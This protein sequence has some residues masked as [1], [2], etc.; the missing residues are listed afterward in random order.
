MHGR[1]DGIAA[2]VF[3]NLGHFDDDGKISMYYLIT[4][5]ELTKSR[6]TT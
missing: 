3:K 5:Q 6:A 4:N 1:T 2:V